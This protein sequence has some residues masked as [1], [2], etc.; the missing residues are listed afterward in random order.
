[1]ILTGT[2]AIVPDRKRR[3]PPW[4]DGSGCIM[5]SPPIDCTDFPELRPSLSIKHSKKSSSSSSDSLSEISWG[6]LCTTGPRS[7][8]R[9]SLSTANS[10]SRNSCSSAAVATT[11]T[12]S[13]SEVA[14]ATLTSDSTGACGC[15]VSSS[16]KIST[17]LGVCI[18]SRI[19]MYLLR[20]GPA[21][22]K[23]LSWS[24]FFEALTASGHFS[25][26]HFDSAKTWQLVILWLGLPQNLQ[27]VRSLV[28]S[29]H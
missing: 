28:S 26:L 7:E 13:L 15:T 19:E 10:R 29:A 8:S 2:P 18:I 14:E 12:L 5:S 22:V 4:A 1:M 23:F 25:P 27:S 6:G 9:R 16:S 3:L 20:P 21:G 11:L 24:S 17:I